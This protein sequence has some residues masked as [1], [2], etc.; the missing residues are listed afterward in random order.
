MDNVLQHSCVGCGYIMGQI[1]PST[2]IL[3][4]YI[5]D[6]GTGIYNSLN[7]SSEHHP[8]TPIDAI[9]MALQEKV[10][11]DTNVGQ[12]NGLWGLSQL[13]TR[14]NGILRVSSG[15]AT[16]KNINGNEII[17]KGNFI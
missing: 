9:T 12:G 2:K 7:S 15:G 1:H 4:F 17:R 3:I 10:T 13:I 6:Y 16:Y 5:F 8:Q 14:S 11:R